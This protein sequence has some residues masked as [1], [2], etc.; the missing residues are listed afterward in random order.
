MALRLRRGTDAERLGFTPLAGELVY[1]T[2][3]KK[4]Y[5]GDGLTAGGTAVDPAININTITDVD[6]E[7][8]APTVGDVL[9]WDGSN[10][11]PAEDSASGL[12]TGADYSINI[13]A[14]D[15]TRMLDVAN[16]ALVGALTGD[17]VGS[18]FADNS[19]VMVDS[20]NGV[21]YGRFVGALDGDVNGSIFSDDSTLLVDSINNVISNNNITLDRNTAFVTADRLNIRRNP[22][23]GNSV[24]LDIS[25]YGLGDAVIIN[26]LGAANLTASSFINFKG[27][28]GTVD[29]PRIANPGE[30]IGGI[31]GAGYDEADNF[32]YAVAGVSFSIDNNET[33]AI[34]NLPG[35]IQMY[36][37]SGDSA[38]VVKYMTFDSSGN[39]A[40]NRTD[41]Q[42][43]LDVNG[44]MLLEPQTGA[45]AAPVEGM[46]A[47]ADR[48]TWD[49]AAKGSG[50]SY[51]VYY[52]G[53]TWNAFY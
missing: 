34:R 35:K 22:F 46:I 32:N 19:S 4:L 17:V 39:L 43:T 47:I 31:L 29:V 23:N 40:I 24:A 28:F 20:V 45:P 6:T 25:S 10:W 50:A 14:A 52:D 2:D 44:V 26:T 42:A 49:P 53:A 51:P 8:T 36:T 48:V 21:H 38:S 15:S 16:N 3:T 11:V 7:S 5:I 12:I 41:A 9:K 18:V 13:V 30:V 27:Q 33:P 1:T 37:L